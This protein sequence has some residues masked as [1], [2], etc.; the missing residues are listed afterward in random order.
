MDTLLDHAKKYK[1]T[2][3]PVLLNDGNLL[4]KDSVLAE[5]VSDIVRRY[6]TNP[7]I[8]AWDLYA[9]AGKTS[10]DTARL[11]N[12]IRLIF[13]FARFEFPN[14]PLT[15]TPNVQ[16]KNFTADFRYREALIHGR[17]A[18]WNN[19]V[20]DG[21]SSPQLC[22]LIWSLS[23]VISFAS[24]QPAPETGWI[25]SIACRYGRPVF[26]TEW[27]PPD[28]ISEHEAL[29]N[30]ARWHIFWYKTNTQWHDKPLIDDFR[31]TLISTP[32]R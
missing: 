9:Y 14:Q 10:T 21:G 28:S 27:C 18:G 29:E 1:T 12:L 3:M 4:C 26:C 23:D 31:F 30:F 11:N 5:Y 24:S 6:A 32:L 22:N 2:V 7:I 19:L 25:Q 20:L 16:V 8:Q 17:Y 15:A 13:R